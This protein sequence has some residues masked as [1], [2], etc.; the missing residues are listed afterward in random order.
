MVFGRRKRGPGKVRCAG[1]LLLLAS[2]VSCGGEREDVSTSRERNPEPEPT[3]PEPASTSK[4][5]DAGEPT[6]MEDAVRCEPGQRR[7]A[8]PE[9]GAE[10]C[11]CPEETRFWTCYGP[12]PELN[13]DTD[14]QCN[15][16]FSL[17]SDAQSCTQNYSGCEDSRTYLVTCSRGFCYCI[18]DA[19]P[20]GELE[21]GSTCPET[22]AEANELCGWG[23]RSGS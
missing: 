17:G 8:T 15:S 9:E 2:A 16:E 22:L 7:D 13:R 5:T 21:P 18:I 3:T 10:Y 20:V 6:Q 23:L 1:W 12:N 4:E 19:E 11:I 14:V